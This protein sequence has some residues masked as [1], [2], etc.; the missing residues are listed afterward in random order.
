VS[1]L[2]C[3]TC[4]M[5]HKATV[6]ETFIPV[7]IRSNEL[8]RFFVLVIDCKVCGVVRAFKM[9]LTFLGQYIGYGWIKPK[10][11]DSVIDRSF[12]KH[13]NLPNN[14]RDKQDSRFWLGCNVYG[15]IQRCYSN[16]SNVKLGLLDPD[17]G[18]DVPPE[19]LK[20]VA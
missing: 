19:F 5:R 8:D 14:N 16:L 7:E 13:K 12:T 3:N 20:K 17:S 15:D 4:G 9:G 1:F 18:L 10:H 11:I 6:Y 2:V